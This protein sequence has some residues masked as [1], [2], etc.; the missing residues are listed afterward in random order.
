MTQ[1]QSSAK[2]FEC[3][4]CGF[5]TNKKSTFSDHISFQSHIDAAMKKL[6]EN[7]SQ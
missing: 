6:Q 5:E 2:K 3:V 1:Q 7:Q 4:K